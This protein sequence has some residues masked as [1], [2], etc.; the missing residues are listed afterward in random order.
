MLTKFPPPRMS[1]LLQEMA[2]TQPGPV[3]QGPW[4]YADGT[5][6]QNDA[7]DALKWINGAGVGQRVALGARRV[8]LELH[9]SPKSALSALTSIVQ[10]T[11]AF[12]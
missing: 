9:D 8:V 11:D 3:G 5:P 10:E 1:K 12:N 7:Q 2:Q 4:R 6:M